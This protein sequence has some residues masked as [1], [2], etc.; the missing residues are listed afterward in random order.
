MLCEFCKKVD[1]YVLKETGKHVFEFEFKPLED[2]KGYNTRGFGYPIKTPEK[3]NKEI[4][5]F[6]NMKLP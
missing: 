6:L 5:E 2:F 4:A 3:A 1:E